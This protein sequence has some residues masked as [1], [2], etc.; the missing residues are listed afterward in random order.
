MACTENKI[1][2]PSAEAPTG[3]SAGSCVALLPEQTASQDL[4]RTVQMCAEAQRRREEKTRALDPEAYRL[5]TCNEAA[6]NGRYRRGKE[7]MSAGDLVRYFYEIR[8]DKIR[9]AD[10]SGNDGMDVCPAAVAESEAGA[11]V[12]AEQSAPSLL[13]ARVRALP[14]RVCKQIRESAPTWFDAARPDSSKESRRFPFSAFA[15]ILAVA[16][17]LMLIVASSILLTRAEDNVNKLRLQIQS[18]SDEVA[19]LKSDFEVKNDWLE[20]RRIAMEEYGM[21]EEDYVKMEYISMPSEDSVEVFE[22]EREKQ[23]GLSAIL[24]AIGIK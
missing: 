2:T 12:E 14:A 1:Y 16:A 13:R 7:S 19:E 20:I 9:H 15:A 10:F 23:V 3:A 21:V 17:S 5:S 24:S 22:E 8:N 18:T 4:V 6:M 11:V